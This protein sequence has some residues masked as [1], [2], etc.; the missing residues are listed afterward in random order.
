MEHVNKLER[1][2]EHINPHDAARVSALYDIRLAIDV[3]SNMHRV[4]AVEVI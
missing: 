3:L 1:H 4:D 2:A